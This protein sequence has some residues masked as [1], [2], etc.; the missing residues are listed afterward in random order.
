MRIQHC[1]QTSAPV[2]LM[3]L[4]ALAAL[5][6]VSMPVHN[7][8]GGVAIAHYEGRVDPAKEM[9]LTV[10]L[11]MH[12]SAGF[13]K[14]LEERYD[15]ASDNFHHWFTAKDFERYAP[16]PEEFE[17][18]KN[19]LVRQGFTVVY[20][21]PMRFSIRVHGTAAVVEKAFHT[22]LN[23]YSYNGRTFQ[24]NARDAHLA[25]PADDLIDGVAGIER[26]ET[27]PRL[28]YVVN[29]KT[30]RPASE[31]LIKTRE[32]LAMFAA[33]LTDTPLSYSTKPVTFT[34]S[35]VSSKFTGYQ[36]LKDGGSAAFT[37]SQLQTH[38]GMPF[39]QDSVTYDGTGQTI[40]LVEGYGYPTAEAD[41]NAAAKV[42]GLP[43]LTGANF[44]VIYPEGKPLNPNAGLLAGWEVEIA[45]DIQSS[46][47]IAPGAKI[48]VVASS[49]QDNEDQLA[50]LTAVI[51][52]GGKPLAYTVSSSW[53]ND[54]EIIS[55]VLEEEAFNKVLKMGSAAG[56][57]FQFS[58]GDSGDRGLGT[59]LGAVGVPANSPYVTAVGGTSILNNPNAT[60]SE[61]PWIVTGWGNDVLYL[62]DYGVVDPLEGYF[63]G[64]AGGGE[65]AYYVRPSWQ[66]KIGILGTGRMV[67]DVAA[68]ADPYTGFPVVFSEY[69]SQYA[70]VV[71]GTSLASP[72]FT[73]TWAIADQYNGKHLGQASIAVSKLSSGEIAD[74]V[75]PTA[76]EDADDVAGS[77][78]DSKTHTYNR[79]TLFTHAIDLDD[80][81]NSLSLY[82]QGAFL[83]AI[84][85]DSFGNSNVT[86]AVSF[87]TDSSLLVSSGWDYATG[88]GEPN[89]ITFV[90]G[91]TGKTTGAGKGEK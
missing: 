2:A 89:G 65:S 55:G 24:A 49:G 22:E 47:S 76:A 27:R 16:T 17:R 46:H 62:Y 79:T 5:P 29:P 33:S 53:E 28:S 80:S 90:Q 10:Q 64:G 14:A 74:V 71:G 37:P 51:N 56:I 36:Y 68:L 32:D 63:N 88:W 7:V 83:S 40:A 61:S 85:P 3:A 70:G 50:S 26:H 77:I 35:G 44:K 11:K 15:P 54:S 60:G 19:E 42:F 31:R 34:G 86:E 20:T 39:S 48:L 30:G 73:A 45:L 18:V 58:S 4:I 66:H 13:D 57:S 6:A 1:L 75:P 84:W 12:D 23:N 43:A 9:N 69:G 21:D 87:G 59:P 81:P 82:G 78:T 91:V 38:Y 52:S 67:P 41:A 72:I 8:P 25:G